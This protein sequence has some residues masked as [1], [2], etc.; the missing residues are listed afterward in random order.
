[1]TAEEF[2]KHRLG[3]YVWLAQRLGEWF[4][5]AVRFDSYDPDTRVEDGTKLN[6]VSLAGHYFFDENV[7]FTIAYDIRKNEEVNG[8]KDKADNILTAQAQY[9]F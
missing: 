3:Y 6:Q 9:D 1:M 2:G 8:I 7:K 4:G 5:A